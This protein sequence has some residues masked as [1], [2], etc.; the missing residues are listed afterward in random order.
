[1]PF[2]LPA[3]NVTPRVEFLPD[4]IWQCDQC[5]KTFDK[6]HQ[7]IERGQQNLCVE[8]SNKHDE[9]AWHCPYCGEEGGEPITIY[10]REY[11]GDSP[12]GGFVEW[13]DEACTLC[14]GRPASPWES[15][16]ALIVENETEECPF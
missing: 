8:C 6:S 4:G 16:P 12:H 1:M 3:R 9:D 7:V 5:E 13:A 11:Q 10:S 14:N 15:Q 2:D